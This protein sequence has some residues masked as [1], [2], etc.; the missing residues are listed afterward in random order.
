MVY[1]TQYSQEQRN[2]KTMLVQDGSYCCAN[3]ELLFPSYPD[4]CP[5]GNYEL[6]ST[7]GHC[8]PNKPQGL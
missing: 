3:H 1:Q 2:N 7:R 6:T 8:F 4:W 5:C